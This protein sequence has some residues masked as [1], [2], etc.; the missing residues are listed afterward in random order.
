MELDRGM[1]TGFGPIG[2][3]LIVTGAFVVVVAGMRT[4]AVLLTPFLLAS[5]IAVI[6]VGPLRVYE[7]PRRA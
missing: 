1:E 3:L 4:A 5:F 7:T 2:R 6:A